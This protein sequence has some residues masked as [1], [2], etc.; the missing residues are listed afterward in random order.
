MLNQ[1]GHSETKIDPAL[2]VTLIFD[3]KLPEKNVLSIFYALAHFAS[4]VLATIHMICGCELLMGRTIPFLNMDYM[5]FG[6]R[7]DIDPWFFCTLVVTVR[8]HISKMQIQTIHA[9][10]SSLLMQILY[11]KCKMISGL[12]RVQYHMIE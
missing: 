1:T 9:L 2:I 4:M 6:R 3:M 8:I 10:S 7:Y 5:I 11:F 12:E